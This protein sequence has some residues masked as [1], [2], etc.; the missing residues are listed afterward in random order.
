MWNPFS[1][2]SFLYAIAKDAPDP[3]NVQFESPLLNL[4]PTELQGKLDSD[5]F[6][7]SQ[8]WVENLSQKVL[9]DVR[10][11]LTSPLQ[12]QPIVR[13]NKRHGA[14]DFRYNEKKLELLITK[15][16]P[17]ESLR[18]SFF[19]DANSIHEF[20]DP[21]IIIGNQQLST[22]MSTLGFYKKYPALL[23]YTIFAIIIAIIL[24]GVLGFFVYISLRDNPTLFPDSKYAVL[25]QASERLSKYGCPLK[26]EEN[27]K[28]LREKLISGHPN[29]FPILLTMNGVESEKGLWKKK[30]IAYIECDMDI[31]H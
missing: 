18:I 13:T 14:V 12:Y 25:A 30:N 8:L 28:E 2:F 20:Q 24:T 3:I 6:F 15:L 9:E 7:V 4:M 16:D 29:G 19:P 17:S 10:I 27:T 31:T 22:V 26:V 11:N 21:Q 5:Y 23:F 1:L